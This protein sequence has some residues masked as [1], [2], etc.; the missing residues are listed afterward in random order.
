MHSNCCSSAK[1]MPCCVVPTRFPCLHPTASS[2]RLGSRY[3]QQKPCQNC[4]K[5]VCPNTQR[6][7]NVWTWTYQVQLQLFT[8]CKKKPSWLAYKLLFINTQ[9]T[10]LWLIYWFEH[11][12]LSCRSSHHYPGSERSKSE[13]RIRSKFHLCCLIRLTNR[14]QLAEGW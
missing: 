5:R 13:I 4:K 2:S 9:S 7:G 1:F 3:K 8:A 10:C 11:F 6:D 14:V 12:I